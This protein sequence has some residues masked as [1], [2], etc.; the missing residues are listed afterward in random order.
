MNAVKNLRET[1][2]IHKNITEIW[3]FAFRGCN[4]LK[5]LVIPEW[6]KHIEYGIVSAHEGFE[7][8]ECHAKGYHVENDAL[9]SNKWN[10][11]ARIL[12]Q[13]GCQTV[14]SAL[15]T[16]ESFRSMALSISHFGAQSPY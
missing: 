8:I 6:V 9:F 2:D 12:P 7:G 10:M 5:R 11:P 4:S 16:I 15:K 3:F 1:I 13:N 14:S